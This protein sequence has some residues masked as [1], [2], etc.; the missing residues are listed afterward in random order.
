MFFLNLYRIESE[1]ITIDLDI[2][3]EFFVG[4]IDSW[5]TWRRYLE[6]HPGADELENLRQK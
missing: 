3:V 6:Q 5:Y 1:D 4:Y 2:S